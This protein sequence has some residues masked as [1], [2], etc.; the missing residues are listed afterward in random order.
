M[1]EVAAYELAVM[2]GLP[3]VPPTVRRVVGNRD[4]TLQLWIESAMS[5]QDRIDQN[6]APP[7]PT[8]WRGVF[9]TLIVFDNLIFNADR[10][11]GNLLIDPD[12]NVWF[13][14]HT[15]GFQI[16]RDLRNPEHIVFCE[17]G[18]WQRLKTLTDDEIKEPLSRY[19]DGRELSALLVRR[20]RLVTHID[21]LIEEN[22]EDAVIF[23]YS[24]DLRDW[25]GASR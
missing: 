23:E 13:I 15:R 16:E 8:W 25:E 14:D 2:L 20:Q 9:G 19:L 3:F 7:N 17:R 4:G 22:G 18:L 5:E 10:N 1:Y 24:Y 6:I 12:W 21:R 11:T